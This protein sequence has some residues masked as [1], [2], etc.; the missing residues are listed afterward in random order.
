MTL[1]GKEDH[2]RSGII[3]GG[4]SGLGVKFKGKEKVGCYGASRVLQSNLK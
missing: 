3:S 2:G 4:K 1:R